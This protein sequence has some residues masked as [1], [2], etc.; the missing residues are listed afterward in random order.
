[1]TIGP[2]YICFRNYPRVWAVFTG[3]DEPRMVREF[4]CRPTKRQI[5]KFKR[6][7]R[8]EGSKL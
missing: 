3:P 5:R 6:A 2:R 8:K 7:A 1:M 4:A